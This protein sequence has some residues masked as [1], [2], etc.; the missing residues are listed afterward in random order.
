MV[1]PD[2]NLAMDRRKVAAMGTA[3]LGFLPLSAAVSDAAAPTV[4]ATA[5]PAVS[6][7]SMIAGLID[8]HR[9]AYAQF[10]DAALEVDRLECSAPDD[11]EIHYYDCP[12]QISHFGPERIARIKAGDQWTLEC[13]LDA[14]I[15]R[16]NALLERCEQREIRLKTTPVETMADLVELLAWLRDRE[17]EGHGRPSG[18]ETGLER[19]DRAVFSNLLAS[20]QRLAGRVA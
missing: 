4:P 18:H 11:V 20:V 10:A 8:A 17:L 5:A 6:T 1:N 9:Q 15:E 16:Y 3:M 12:G 14:A 7:P 13:G 19:A 2:H